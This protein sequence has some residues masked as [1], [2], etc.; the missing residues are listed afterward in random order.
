[1]LA[2]KAVLI[3]ET[4]I[5][6][7]LS[8]Q[9]ALQSLNAYEIVVLTSAREFHARKL[10]WQDVAC[11]IIEIERDRDQQIAMV[12]SAQEHNVPVLGLTADSRLKNGMPEFPGMPMLVKPVPDEALISAVQS[13]LQNTADQNE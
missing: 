6:I 13:L 12:R 5:I 10:S 3:I 8:M 4:E 11:A 1:M 9:A 2:R 7:S